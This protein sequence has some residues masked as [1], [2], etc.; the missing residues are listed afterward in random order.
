ME[1][2]KQKKKAKLPKLTKQDIAFV[3]KVVETGKLTKSAQEAYNLDNQRYAGVKAQRLIAKDNIIQAIE[4]KRK[5]LKQA[6]IDKGITEDKIAEKIEVLLE[7]QTEHKTESG[8]TIIKKDYNAI[9]KGLKHAT[10]IYGVED[11]NDK[12][13][14]NVYNFFFEPTFQKSIKN[15]DQ[16][17][18]NLIINRQ[19]VQETQN[20]KEVVDTD[21]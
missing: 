13:K 9:D 5:S 2:T 11:L 14:E 15:Y 7:A 19:N 18:K 10:N 12:P 16:N 21:E 3:E 17:I 4:V 8:E 20:I 1:Q 6:L